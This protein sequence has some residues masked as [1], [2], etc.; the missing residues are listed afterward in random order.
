M[1]NGYV[2]IGIIALLFLSM[3][4]YAYASVAFE[5]MKGKKAK[6]RL[7]K[8]REE[9]RIMKLSNQIERDE[10]LAK[11]LKRS[12]EIRQ[13]L[14]ELEL[15]KEMKEQMMNE[16]LKLARMKTQINEQQAG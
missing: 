15:K 7:I 11:L 8:L 2:I 4:G 1:D 10:K 16:K 6:K 13:E 12:E 14:R 5:N 3:Y 9:R